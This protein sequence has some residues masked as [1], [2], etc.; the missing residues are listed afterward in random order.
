MN[1][2][3]WLKE[4]LESKFENFNTKLDDFCLKNA[5]EHSQIIK[6][7]DYTNGKVRRL[8]IWRGY[9]SGGV[10]V[11]AFILGFLTFKIQILW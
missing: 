5:G 4:L 9:L 7:L 6:R 1:E 11:L 2:N 8:E 3:K 10:A